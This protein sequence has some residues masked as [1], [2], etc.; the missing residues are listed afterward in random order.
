M[1]VSST[2][3]ICH[4]GSGRDFTCQESIGLSNAVPIVDLCKKE[5]DKR[6]YGVFAGVLDVEDGWTHSNTETEMVSFKENLEDDE[7]RVAINSVGEGGI[8]GMNGGGNRRRGLFMFK[9][10]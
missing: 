4:F 7:V 5:K 6:I 10:D 3:D 2:N 8:L 9:F 1:I